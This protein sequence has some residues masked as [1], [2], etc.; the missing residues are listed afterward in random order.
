MVPERGFGHRMGAIQEFAYR[1][2]FGQTSE[3][4]NDREYISWRF[5]D[6]ATAREFCRLFDAEYWFDPPGHKLRLAQP[7]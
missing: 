6:E 7:A 2:P 4:A 1:Q 3:R 5:T